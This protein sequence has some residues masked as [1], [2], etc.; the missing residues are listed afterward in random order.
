MIIIIISITEHIKYV[1]N[2]LLIKHELKAGCQ[3]P[4]PK[5]RNEKAKNNQIQYKLKTIIKILIDFNILDL[6]KL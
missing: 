2:W 4:T 5:Q 1:G 6:N 3:I